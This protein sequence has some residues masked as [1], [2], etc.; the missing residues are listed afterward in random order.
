MKITTKKTVDV[1]ID[2][3]L[4]SFIRSKSKNFYFK[5]YSEKKCI[6]ISEDEISIK[7][8]DIFTVL[9]YEFCTESE[10]LEMYNQVN[11]KLCQ[12]ATV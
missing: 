3:P 11:L 4:P 2:I 1:E 6:S 12:L 8:A 10:F 9:D 5:V 7:S